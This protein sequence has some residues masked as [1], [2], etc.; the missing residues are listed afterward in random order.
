MGGACV[1]PI[2]KVYDDQGNEIPIAAVRGPAGATYTP[3]ISDNGV[4]SWSNNS[5]LPNPDEFDIVNA[6]LQALPNYNEEVF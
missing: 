5:L 3:K 2:L 6:V 4:L 1:K